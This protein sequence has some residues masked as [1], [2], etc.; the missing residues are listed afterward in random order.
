LTE[1]KYSFSSDATFRRG[2]GAQNASSR[3]FALGDAMRS[4]GECH[5]MAMSSKGA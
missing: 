1:P 3:A 2:S 5:E 4:D